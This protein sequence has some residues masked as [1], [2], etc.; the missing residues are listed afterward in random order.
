[1]TSVEEQYKELAKSAPISAPVG[2][3]TTDHKRSRPSRP[4]PPT[5]G[6]HGE[7]KGETFRATM[8][9]VTDLET[10]ATVNAQASAT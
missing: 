9:K 7:A 8:D 6:L 3:A 1:M 5:R 2:G 4:A 10:A